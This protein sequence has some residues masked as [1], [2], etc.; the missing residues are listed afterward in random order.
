[1]N[2]SLSIFFINKQ[3]KSIILYK[4]FFEILWIWLNN[5]VR[6][7]ETIFK[8]C[9]GLNLCVDGYNWILDWTSKDIFKIIPWMN[10][11]IIHNDR[12]AY[13]NI[14]LNYTVFTDDWSLNFNTILYLFFI[15]NYWI[16]SFLKIIIITGIYRKW[17]ILIK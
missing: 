6:S 5:R 7:C 10:Y 2:F 4:G 1:M 14:I 16:S 13:F 3:T 9:I 11:Y 17:N 15:F 8:R 12:V